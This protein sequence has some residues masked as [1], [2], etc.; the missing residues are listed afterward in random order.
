MGP[1][2][3]ELLSKFAKTKSDSRKF[4][5]DIYRYTDYVRLIKVR[6]M[7]MN[8]TIN[9]YQQAV[10]EIL[11][12]VA[13]CKFAK[14]SIDAT[15]TVLSQTI[16]E[17]LEASDCSVILKNSE[18]KPANVFGSN[19]DIQKYRT[20]VNDV[21]VSGTSVMNVESDENIICAAI[22]TDRSILGVITA[23]SQTCSW[24]ENTIKVLELIGQFVGLEI[25]SL[26]LQQKSDNNERLA[27]A[28]RAILDLSHSVKNILQMVGGAAEVIDLG[29][30]TKQ[31]DRVNRSWSILKPNLD[32]LRKFMLDMLDFSKERPLEIDD[33][34]FNKM[35]QDAIESLQSQLKQKLSQLN[36]R[37]DQKMPVV[38]LDSERILEMALNIILNAIDIVDEDNG[39]VC[40]ETHYLQDKKMVE[41]RVA[42]NGPGMDEKMKDR[43][44]VPFESGNSKFGT[45]LGMAIAKRIIDS[46]K[47]NI[48]VHT[49][50][51]EGTTI[52]VRLPAEISG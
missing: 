52:I 31:M 42:D 51:G 10:P 2:L 23:Q 37:I 29:L 47:G 19:I 34:D 15:L 25:N 8:S 21:T 49:K 16:G 44:F 11:E 4:V 33:C 18:G 7:A 46:H 22:K 36:M 5:S 43:L 17:Y 50:I 9:K 30:K 38:K 35:I 27:T 45:G 3:R 14:D 40:V 20:T 12:A 26:V 32:R 24:N 39:I 28:G 13:S 1:G 6:F 41:L 48:E